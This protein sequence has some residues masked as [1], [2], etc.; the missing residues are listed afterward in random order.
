[1]KALEEIW[2]IFWKKK[3]VLLNLYKISKL[4]PIKFENKIYKISRNI[5]TKKKYQTKRI[6]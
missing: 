5:K 6:Y 3:H 1:M 4:Q 2:K